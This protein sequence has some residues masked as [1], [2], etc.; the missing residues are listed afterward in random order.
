MTDMPARPLTASDRPV[1]HASDSDQ[2][3]R[4]PGPSRAGTVKM[5][6]D[7]MMIEGRRLRYATSDNTDAC[8]PEGLGSEP[9]WAVNIHGYF[10]GGGMYWR[11]S[12]H[13]AQ[14][15][16][17]RVVNP[18]L[19]GFAGSDPLPWER[20]SMAE[21]AGQ[22][23]ALLDH[24]G[25]RRAILLGHSMGG[26]V[27]VKLAARDPARTLGIIYRDGAA[28]PA[29]KKRHGPLVAA[30][31]PL[32]PDVAGIADLVTAVVMDFPDL[33][34]GRRIA[35]TMRGM[36]PDARRN[37]RTLG[38]TLPVGA[39]LF[40]VDLSDEVARIAADGEIPILPAWGCFDRIANLATAEEFA[41]LARSDI[42]W[43]PGGHSWMLARPRGQGDA[44]R[45]L[46]QGQA[47]LA[48]VATRRTRLLGLDRRRA[49]GVLRALR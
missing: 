24:L 38:R 12:S 25:I 8:G 16:G 9:V 4:A 37:I 36:W 26:A 48:Q 35:S 29:W 34:V 40:A 19:P 2:A 41:R 43:I 27:A 1:P 15:L 3:S 10:A 33:L 17:W 6:P 39:M 49:K 46:A 18:S 20:V 31:A 22:V 28:T 21:I 45:F 5:L 32:V 42:M 13:L 44:L 14:T 47:F 11:E 23:T 7:V 30:L